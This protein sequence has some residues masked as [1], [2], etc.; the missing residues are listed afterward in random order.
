MYESVEAMLLN[1]QEATINTV[2]PEETTPG[3]ELKNQFKRLNFI[4]GS[5]DKNSGKPPQKDQK[6]V[7]DTPT[8][9]TFSSIFLKRPPKPSSGSPADKTAI[10]VESDW[11]II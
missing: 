7:E 10:S 8:R 11:T 2:H 1:P 4:F 3:G 5:K 9:Q 6:N